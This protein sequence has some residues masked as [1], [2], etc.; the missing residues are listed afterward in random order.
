MANILLF[1]QLTETNKSTI[2]NILFPN[3]T[4]SKSFAYMPSGGAYG[5][6]SYIAQW[7]NIANGYGVRFSVIDNASADPREGDK[8]LNA[9]TVLISG[10]NTFQLLSNLRESGLDKTILEF[11]HK[12]DNTLAG[13]SA[14]ALVLTPTITICNL[15]GFDKNIVGL[16]N[17]DGLG[18]V[19]FEI[20]PHYKKQSC[21]TVINKYR[22]TT[23]NQ[24]REITDEAYISLDL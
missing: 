23:N 22:K 7:E 13:F 12:Q 21:E 18:I 8:L 5:A 1:S 3:A 24:V 14:G 2:L 9:D 20:F 16:D 11:S 15:P 19:D 6:E 17:L 4:T 10:G